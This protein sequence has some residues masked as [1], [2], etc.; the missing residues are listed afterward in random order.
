MLESLRW[1]MSLHRNRSFLAWMQ[2]TYSTD[3]LRRL[4]SE[5]TD[6]SLTQPYSP[7]ADRYYTRTGRPM[8]EV[9][10][11]VV[12]RLYKRYH[13]DIWGLCLEAGGHYT[14]SGPFGLE[15]LAQLDRC[16]EV[17]D[18]HIFEEFLVRNALKRG[19]EAVLERLQVRRTE[20]TKNITDIDGMGKR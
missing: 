17:Y 4:V 16:H 8:G 19:A 20:T 2:D 6:C 18:Q 15:S 11:E 13:S 3:E 1:W 5:A 12:H 7:F 14:D 9:L 10:S